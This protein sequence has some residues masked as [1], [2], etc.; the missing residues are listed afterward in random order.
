MRLI[1]SLSAAPPGPCA[2]PGRSARLHCRVLRGAR[3]GVHAVSNEHGGEDV[4]TIR[5]TV[6]LARLSAR[7]GVPSS[8]IGRMVATPPRKIS[9]LD[10]VDLLAL[11]TV[12]RDPFADMGESAS[13]NSERNGSTTCGPN[14]ENE[15]SRLE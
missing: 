13:G 15:V 14:A 2:S 8:V 9:Y 4:G 1:V 7:L 10:E 11:K 3:I 6:E 12:V 5:D